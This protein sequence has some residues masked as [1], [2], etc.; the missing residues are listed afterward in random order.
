MRGRKTGGRRPGSG[1]RVSRGVKVLAQAQTSVAVETLVAIMTRPTAMD[2]ARVRAACELLD[3]GWGRA[4]KAVT[5]P[6][7]VGPVLVKVTH[8]HHP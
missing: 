3:R 1:N 6:E 8:V 7:G 2:G 5:G 4:P